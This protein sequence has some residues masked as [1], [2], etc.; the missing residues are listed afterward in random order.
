MKRLKTYAIGDVVYDWS[1]L[2]RPTAT[3]RDLPTLMI[4]NYSRSRQVITRTLEETTE[5]TKSV[6]I[7]TEQSIDL[8]ISLETEVDDDN[9]ASMEL[10]FSIGWA[11]ERGSSETKSQTSTVAVTCDVLAEHRMYAYVT[12]D[13]YRTRVPWKGKITKIYWDGSIKVEDIEGI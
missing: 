7:S 6:S 4:D 13:T 5:E 12:A 2:E 11:K 1:R 10:A 8:E 9:S 3:P